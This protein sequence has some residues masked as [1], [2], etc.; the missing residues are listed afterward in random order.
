MQRVLGSINGGTKCIW[1][2]LTFVQTVH[3]IDISLDWMATATWTATWMASMASRWRHR[4]CRSYTR[5]SPLMIKW[6]FCLKRSQWLNNQ[7]NDDE[8]TTTTTNTVQRRHRGLGEEM[9]GCSPSCGCWLH[10]ANDKMMVM[11][12]R[13]QQPKNCKWAVHRLYAHSP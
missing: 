4:S 9:K 12:N 1:N 5:S 10:D 13:W 8:Q 6:K 3:K 2:S 7:P 11:T